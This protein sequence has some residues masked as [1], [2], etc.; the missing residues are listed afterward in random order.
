M[1]VRRRHAVKFF[2][3]SQTSACTYANVRKVNICFELLTRGGEEEE[4]KGPNFKMFLENETL[5]GANC[6]ELE[7]IVFA[8]TREGEKR[9]GERTILSRLEIPAREQE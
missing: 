5:L 2:N 9:E 8:K 6:R 7:H 4:K 3:K 1:Y